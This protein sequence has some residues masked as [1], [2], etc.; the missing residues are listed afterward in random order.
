MQELRRRLDDRRLDIIGY[1][2]FLRP[3]E[4]YRHRTSWTDLVFLICRH[5]AR[6]RTNYS[7][8][9]SF[10]L[11]ISRIKS[12]GSIAQSLRRDAT[13]RPLEN[14][15]YLFMNEYAKYVLRNV[16][17][18]NYTNWRTL[19]LSLS[20][21]DGERFDKRLNEFEGFSLNGKARDNC[22]RREREFAECKRMKSAFDRIAV[23]RSSIRPCV[24]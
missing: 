2:F 19:S 22:R 9:G 6:T 8:P 15:L 3:R 4:R 23:P 12:L 11:L 16:R 24:C 7:T 10:C 17:T 13:Q 18:K 20:R 1:L 14:A 5:D 21:R